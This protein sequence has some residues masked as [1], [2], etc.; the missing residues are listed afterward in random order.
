[1]ADV[2]ELLNTTSENTVICQAV[3]EHASV[4]VA[5]KAHP[6]LR[7]KSCKARFR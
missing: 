4:L 3:H 6:L 2:A 7:Q 1:M 5:D